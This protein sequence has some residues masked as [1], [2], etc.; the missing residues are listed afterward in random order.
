M[1]HF[2]PI[3][4]GGQPP[5]AGRRV[6]LAG[7]RAS[8]DPAAYAQLEA[9]LMEL[10]VIETPVAEAFGIAAR[11]LRAHGAEVTCPFEAAWWRGAGTDTDRAQLRDV[12]AGREHDA[13]ALES[14][15]L[16]VVLDGWED[17]PGAV[18]AAVIV[19]ETRDVPWARVSAVLASCREA[20]AVAED[21]R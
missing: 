13:R 18:D 1:R 11:A 5:L 12:R 19:A 20:L 7:P 9:A 14:A 3:V 21:I 6:Y 17:V 2:A 10:G 16:V 4:T 8:V 15:D